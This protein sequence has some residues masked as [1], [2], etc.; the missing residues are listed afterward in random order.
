MAVVRAVA[1]QTVAAAVA[2]MGV[3]MAVRRAAAT[4]AFPVASSVVLVAMAAVDRSAAGRSA[5]S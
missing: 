1:A 5:R 2:W 4:E 3:W